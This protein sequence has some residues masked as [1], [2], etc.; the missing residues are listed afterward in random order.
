MAEEA[1]GKVS[2]SV[3]DALGITGPQSGLG[4]SALVMS[5]DEIVVTG[6]ETD[7]C[8]KGTESATEWPR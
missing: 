4:R 5:R 7:S 1:T 2:S 6:S 3:N 8:G